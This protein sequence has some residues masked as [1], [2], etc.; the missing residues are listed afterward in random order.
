M[1]SRG[2]N[3]LFFEA[4]IVG[5]KIDV[6]TATVYNN[7]YCSS[8]RGTGM[9]SETWQDIHS[10]FWLGATAGAALFL[11]S[12]VIGFGLHLGWRLG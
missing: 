8:S 4:E 1:R 2:H 11:A 5:S 12:L 9:K 3:K 10:A 7:T 6:S